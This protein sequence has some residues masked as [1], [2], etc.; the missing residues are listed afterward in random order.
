VTRASLSSS[1]SRLA[2]TRLATA[3]RRDGS[4][5]TDSDHGWVDRVAADPGVGGR[6]TAFGEG[7]LIGTVGSATL[8]AEEIVGRL[9]TLDLDELRES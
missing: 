6:E 8:S 2:A 3:R 4:A 1:I 5:R 9:D 7:D